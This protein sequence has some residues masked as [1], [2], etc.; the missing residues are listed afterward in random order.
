M[1]SS[2]RP[3]SPHRPR[4]APLRRCAALAVLALMPQAALAQDG[5]LD[6]A[7]SGDTGWLLIAALLVLLA[8]VPG[9]GLYHGARVRAGNAVSAMLQAAAVT[10]AVSLVW[11]IVGY[12]VAFGMVTNGWLGSGNAWMLIELGN[13]R[14]NTGAP[15]SAFALYQIV[16]AALAAVLMTGAWAGRARFGWALAFCTLWSLVVYAPVAH[17]IWGGG[18]LS[19]GV[20]TLDWGGGI[21][22]ETTA[23]VSALVVAIMLGR[24]KFATSDAAPPAFGALT[25]AGLVWLGWLGLVGGAALAANDDAAAAIIAAH[26]AAAA[27]ALT[28]LALDNWRHGKPTAAGFAGGAIAGLAIATPAAGYVSPGAAILFGIV[29]AAAC[30]AATR[31]FQDRLGI[32]DRLSVFATF[33][34]GGLLGALLLGVFTSPSLGGVGYDEGM[35]MIAQMTAQVVAMLVVSVWAIIATVILAVMASTLFP[36][37]VSEDAERDGLDR[38]SHGLG[39]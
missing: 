37:R 3:V 38:A 11:I 7:D 9:L 24:G 2:P 30:R 22:I 13:V 19:Q 21:V 1:T 15:E 35:G 16:L 23:G 14:Q 33:G 20:G 5:A 32:D 27:G 26:A 36:M 29:G 12:T 25:G 34:I 17:W 18:W 31:L 28:G 4:R 10:M 6:V 39:D 8:A